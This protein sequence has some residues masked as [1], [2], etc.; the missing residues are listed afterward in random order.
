M[1]IS[2]SGSPDRFILS[3]V[4]LNSCLCNSE[5]SF[6]VKTVVFSAVNNFPLEKCFKTKTRLCQ[7]C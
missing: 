1:K 3:S 6:F 2:H 4:S 7:K 5:R